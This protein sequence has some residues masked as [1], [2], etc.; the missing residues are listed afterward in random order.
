MQRRYTNRLK[1]LASR[2]FTMTERESCSQTLGGE[3]TTL[4]PIS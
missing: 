3:N 4:G 2:C 1:R